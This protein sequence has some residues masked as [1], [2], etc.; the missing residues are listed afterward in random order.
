MELPLKDS[1]CIDDIQT[2]VS[3]ESPVNQAVDTSGSLPIEPQTP[4]TSHEPSDTDS[5]LPTTPSS[6][7]A[8]PLISRVQNQVSAKPSATAVPI[9]PVV[10]IL[11]PSPSTPRLPSKAAVS[12]S[13]TTGETADSESG[14][15][16]SGKVAVSGPSEVS[17]DKHPSPPKPTAP[18]SWAD[19]VRSKTQPR[20]V[21][22]AVATPGD[23]SG[24]IATRSES[25][26]DAL[27]SI[28]TDVEQYADKIAFLEPR[29][30]VNTGNMC[31][32][33]SVRKFECLAP[34]LSR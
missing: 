11:P 7:V 25:L 24:L 5:T 33:N 32:M 30:L 13:S 3:Q 34:L 22:L 29:G 2:N 8:T 1:H 10:P 14:V 12:E 18:K 6:A 15:T 23:A 19:L 16:D 17:Q 31:Y 26:V 28:G 27:N 4:G 9:V 20:V 21:D